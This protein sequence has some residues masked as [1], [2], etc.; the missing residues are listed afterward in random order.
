MRLNTIS[1]LAG[2]TGALAVVSALAVAPASAAGPADPSGGGQAQDQSSRENC[3]AKP[4]T[5]K[6]DRAGSATRKLGKCGGVL[7]PP[8]INDP[9]L[10]KPAPDAGEMP[11]IK[12]GE[13][14]E[15]APKQK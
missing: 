3:Q 14:P 15:Q 6:D 7:Q 1:T 13:V 8:E 12:P 11:V 10:V 4:D 2:F 9:G 5:K